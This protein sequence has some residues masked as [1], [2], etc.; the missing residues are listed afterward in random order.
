MD[1][2]TQGWIAGLVAAAVT[3]AFTAWWESRQHRRRQ[4]DDAVTA[5]AEANLELS[6]ELIKMASKGWD[7][8]WIVQF[9]SPVASLGL[10]VQ[11]LAGRRILGVPARLASPAREGLRRS[12]AAR[13]TEFNRVMGAV[14]QDPPR[15]GT[16]EA[17]PRALLVRVAPLIGASNAEVAIC[18]AWLNNP[19]R[20]YPC[21]DLS[22]WAESKKGKTGVAFV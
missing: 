2:A 22:G 21:R 5:L 13:S 4:L 7:P 8:S 15:E 6:N 17:E 11:A 3:L 20:F 10:R 19:W 1:N 12:T 18:N 9:T 14:S 16:D